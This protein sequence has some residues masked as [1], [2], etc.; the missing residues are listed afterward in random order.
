MHRECSGTAHHYVHYYSIVSD[1]GGCTADLTTLRR[2]HEHTVN[3]HALCTSYE[4]RGRANWGTRKLVASVSL[5]LSLT[6][7]HVCTMC[8]LQLELEGRSF[9]SNSNS[10]RFQSPIKFYFSLAHTHTG[11]GT[12]TATHQLKPKKKYEKL[13][14][15][16]TR[17]TTARIHLIHTFLDVFILFYFFFSSFF[18]FLCT[19]HILHVCVCQMKTSSTRFWSKR[20]KKNRRENSMRPSLLLPLKLTNF[21][22]VHVR[23]SLSRF[24]VSMCRKSGWCFSTRTTSYETRIRIYIPSCCGCAALVHSSAREN[25]EPKRWFAFNKT[26]QC[27][28]YYYLI[29]ILWIKFMRRNTLD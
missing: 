12:Q 22:S 29:R 6:W 24:D 19:R 5:S 23:K 18:C 16:A 9:T 4:L 3:M 26:K 8:C 11:S 17:R 13:W 7:R 2:P 15:H 21:D 1:S 20:R 28:H 10:P 14:S 27:G 25:R